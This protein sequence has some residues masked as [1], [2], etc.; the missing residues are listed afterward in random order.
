MDDID[1]EIL[2]GI[3]KPR[4]RV[5]IVPTASGLEDTPPSWV[6]LAQTHFAALGADVVPV[7]VVRREDARERKWIDAVWDVD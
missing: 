6:A 4:A 7:M 2:A 5:A 3:G 1:R